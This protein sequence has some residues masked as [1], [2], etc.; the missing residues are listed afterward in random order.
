MKKPPPDK[1]YLR[2]SEFANGRTN[3]GGGGGP[4]TPRILDSLTPLPSNSEAYLIVFFLLSFLSAQLFSGGLHASGNKKGTS[5]LVQA[6][7]GF[8][9]CPY[10][11]ITGSLG[12]GLVLGL[13]GKFK[14]F[15]LRFY[16]IGALNNAKY[17]HKDANTKT[18]EDYSLTMNFMDLGAGLRIL[19][20]IVSKFRVYLDVVGIG[21]HQKAN[22]ARDGARD[23]KSSGWTSGVIV[24]G[25]AEF[26]WHKN[27]ATGL[28]L[29]GNFYKKLPGNVPEIVGI[30]VRGNGRLFIGIT[31]S[32]LF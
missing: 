11:R 8:A 31:Q 29:E 32:F 2:V 10:S 4:L 16:L 22:L 21:S 14:G 27:L 17:W 5:I 24:A 3:K 28:R 25:G 20:P 6:E 1:I 30:E 12:Y 23:V 26:R 13:G 9:S 7:G 18:G 19:V 15:P